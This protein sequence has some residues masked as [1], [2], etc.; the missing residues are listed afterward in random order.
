MKI[1]ALGMQIAKEKGEIEK[2][3]KEPKEL[4][5]F[6]PKNFAGDYER[7]DELDENSSDEELEAEEVVEVPAVKDEWNQVTDKRRGN[8]KN[9]IVK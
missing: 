6:K 4:T 9:E 7:L 2:V 1:I 3:R 8:K 5:E